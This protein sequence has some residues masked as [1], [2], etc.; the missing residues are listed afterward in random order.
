MCNVYLAHT[1]GKEKNKS[2]VNLQ[3][4]T[5]LRKLLKLIYSVFRGKSHKINNDFTFLIIF[6][7]CPKGLISYKFQGGK[8]LDCQILC[9]I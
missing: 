8:G 3:S 1:C 2:R 7:I 4:P 9:K 5:N 6:H